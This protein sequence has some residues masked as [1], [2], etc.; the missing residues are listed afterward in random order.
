[1]ARRKSKGKKPDA[2]L[3]TRRQLAEE[4][5]VHPITVTKWERAGLPIAEQGRRGKPSMYRRA[6]VDAWL[7]KRETDQTA[8]HVDLARER[9]LL[10]QKQR[11]RIEIEIAVN[12]GELV[13][14][15]QVV[16][17]GQAHVKG[18]TAKIRSL[19]R[20][21]AQAGIIQPEQ[22]AGLEGLCREILTE[23]S[24]WKTVA[25]TTRPTKTKRKKAA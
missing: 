17:E 16:R 25:D 21:A 2:G 18:W 6:D 5:N 14:R 22:V 7:A 23:I 20:R 10:A 13:H 15:D 11:E 8:E 4:L 9:A 19:A 1:M 12:R 24:R 3:V